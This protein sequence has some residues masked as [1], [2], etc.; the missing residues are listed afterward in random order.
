[1]LAKEGLEAWSKKLNNLVYNEVE[2][3]FSLLNCSN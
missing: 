2:K 3:H 1:M